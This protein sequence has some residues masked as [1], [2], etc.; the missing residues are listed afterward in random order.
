MRITV[1]A[2]GELEE[3]IQEQMART[4]LAAGSVTRELA[5]AGMEYRKSLKTFER[6]AEALEKQE[7]K[8]REK[9]DRKSS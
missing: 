3:Y 6:L 2:K 4:G 8:G 7:K 1:I 5:Q 9:Y